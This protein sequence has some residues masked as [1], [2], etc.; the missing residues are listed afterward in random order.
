M[1]CAEKL[2]LK[3]TLEQQKLLFGGEKIAF[4]R[5]WTS[6]DQNFEYLHETKLS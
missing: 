5:V 6:N 2:V 4:P 3:E 1:M